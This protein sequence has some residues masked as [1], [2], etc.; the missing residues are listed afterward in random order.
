M[1]TTTTT[2]AATKLLLNTEATNYANAATRLA[3]E[4]CNTYTHC[5]SYDLQPGNDWAALAYKCWA[6]KAAKKASTA[7]GRANASTNEA[8]R[9]HWTNQAAAAAK[10]AEIAL[11]GLEELAIQLLQADEALIELD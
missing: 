3:C 2:T 4:A 6:T 1:T 8:D 5:T 7:A 11:G 10:E 9:R